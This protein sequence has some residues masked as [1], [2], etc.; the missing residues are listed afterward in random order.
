MAIDI[1]R[2]HVDLPP[3]KAGDI[4]TL[5]PVGAYNFTQ[6]MQFIT[7][8]PAVA[9]INEDGSV[10]LI[11]HAEKLEDIDGPELMPAHLIK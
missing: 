5:H 10:E 11:R 6:S 4:L 3:L 2:Y 8:R 1:V 9:L 7:F